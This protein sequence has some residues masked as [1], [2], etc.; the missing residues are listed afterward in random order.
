MPIYGYLR[1]P[2]YRR[3]EKYLNLNTPMLFGFGQSTP[4]EIEATP[5]NVPLDTTDIPGLFGYV[6]I[7]TRK[8]V[9]KTSVL[10]PGGFELQGL[11]YK[12]VN[13][14]DIRDIRAN[15]IN[16]LYLKGYLYHEDIYTKVCTFRSLSVHIDVDLNRCVTGPYRFLGPQNVDRSAA[17][18]LEHF[19]PFTVQRSIRQSFELV[20]LMD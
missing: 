14:N 18:Y 17:M 10:E 1:E 2:I 15:R 16:R 11:F 8:A 9:I 19:P 7:T 5:P 3:V 13:I 12:T 6:P 20:V 4:W